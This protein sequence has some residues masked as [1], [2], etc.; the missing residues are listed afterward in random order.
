TSVA[1]E[2]LGIM[3]KT[4]DG[5]VIAEKD[6][7]LRGPGELL[8]TKQSGLP[9]FRIANL[10]RDQRILEAARKEADFYLNKGERFPETS[11]MIQ[12]IKTDPRFGLAVVG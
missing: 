6:L 7:E 8:G 4:N 1:E 10:V 12:R 3:A 2:R 11:K 5:F 9:E